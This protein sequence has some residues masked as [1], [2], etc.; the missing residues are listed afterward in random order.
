MTVSTSVPSILDAVGVDPQRAHGLLGEALAGADDG[1]L[2]LERS[3]SESFLFD[4]GRLKSA[5]YDSAEGFG[6]RVVAGETAGYAHASEV[7]EAAIRRAAD[8]AKLAKRGYEGV[9]AEGPRATHTRLYG[10]DD[11]LASP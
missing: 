6:L 5:T 3:E 11:P 7:S 8:S 4:D 10:A 2:F 1:E 9:S